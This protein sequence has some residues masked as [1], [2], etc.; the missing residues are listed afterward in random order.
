MSENTPNTPP[1]NPSIPPPQFQPSPPRPQPV[2]GRYT[3]PPYPPHQYQPPPV[4]SGGCTRFFL[5]GIIALIVLGMIGVGTLIGSFF[6]FAIATDGMNELMADRQEKVLTERTIGG[7]RKAENRIAVITVEGMIR[8]NADGYIARQIRQVMSDSKVKAVV[9]RVDSP[10]GTMA[11]SDYYL[12]LLKRMKSKR[13]I[14]VVVSMGGIAASGGYYVSTVG[15]VIFAEPSTITGSIGV[16]ASLFDASELLKNVGVEATP[17]VSG[18]YKTM[19]SLTRPMTEEERELWQHLI[20]DN[21][22][23]FKKVIREGRKHFANNPEE[24]DT[25]ATGQV[26]TANDALAN[27]LIDKIGF[28]D[29]AVEQAGS[30]A[31]MADRDYRVIQYKP[32]LSF[33]DALLES[34]A[35]NKLLSGKTVFE[36][37]TPRIYLLHPQVIPFHETE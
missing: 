17:V 16:V 28:I 32:K 19:G 14:P 36:M 8:S 3:P 13:D 7:N 15:D 1:S 9:L 4:R 22:D 27:K 5:Y 34:R 6:L 24:L 10:G 35:P 26:F 25:V 21:F 37:T 18:Q 33:M 20:D 23:R 2:T 30:L 12:H 11:G 29:D 31:N